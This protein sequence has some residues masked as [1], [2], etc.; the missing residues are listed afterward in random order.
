[1][2]KGIGTDDHH[3]PHEHPQASPPRLGLHQYHASSSQQ[4]LSPSSS[5]S[6]LVPT[7]S[8]YVATPAPSQQTA[9]N[10][11]VKVAG[12][13]LINLSV[14]IN[15]VLPSHT[16]GEQA[17]QSSYLW[18]SILSRFR[19]PFSGT[20][21]TLNP[22]MDAPHEP[23]PTQSPAP[24]CPDPRDAP[25][26]EIQQTPATQARDLQTSS[27]VYH[28]AQD[29]GPKPAED[30]GPDD[31]DIISLEDLDISGEHR[32]KLFPPKS[33]NLPKA[34]NVHETYLRN[35]YPSGHGYPCA[36]PWPMGPPIRIG[37]VGIH[38]SSGFAVLINL[39]DCQSTSLQNQLSSLPS[40]PDVWQNP[41]YLSEGESVVGGISDCET[42]HVPESSTI[43]EIRYR[44]Q[45]SEGAILAV[46]SPAELLSLKD[47]TPLRDWLCKHGM[48]LFQS[49]RPG[50]SDPL[51]VVTGTVMSSSWA[52]ATYAEPMDAP[53]NLLVLA[54]L[55]FHGPYS[56]SSYRWTRTG[57]AQARSRTSATLDSAGESARD[58]CLFLRGFL[59]TPSTQHITDRG[60]HGVR[61]GDGNTA[62]GSDLGTGGG[63]P[64][65]NSFESFVGGSLGSSSFSTGSHQ[66][67]ASD[68]AVLGTEPGCVSGRVV[69]DEVPSLTSTELYPSHI[70]NKRLLELTNANLAITHDDDWRSRLLSENECGFGNF[71][72][73]ADAIQAKEDV[74]KRLGGNIGMPND[75]TVWIG[76]GQADSA[77]GTLAKSN[78][79]ASPTPA[80]PSVPS[81]P[82]NSAAG[83]NSMDTQLRSAPSRA[84]RIGPIPSTATPATILDVFSPYEPIEYDSRVPAKAPETKDSPHSESSLKSPL[85]AYPLSA[86]FLIAMS[87]LEDINQLI[88]PHTDAIGIFRRV[89]PY[90]RDL[91][92]LVGFASTA[93]A[94]CGSGTILGNIVRASIDTR[95][96]HCNSVLSQ[97]LRQIRRLPYRS[98][99]RT[100]Y[101]YSVVHEWWTGNEPEEIRT[102]RL[103]ISEEAKAIGEWMRCLHSFWWASSQLLTTN[104]TFSM[105]N[106]HEF[107]KSGPI[108]MLR[109]IVIEEIMFLEPLQGERRSIPIRFVKSFEDVHM[110]IGMACRGTAASRFIEQRQYQLDESTTDATVSEENILQRIDECR[111]FEITITFSRLEVLADVCPRCET[112]QGDSIQRNGNGWVQCR[113]C[114]MKFNAHTSMPV[115]AKIEEIDQGEG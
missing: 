79:A 73:Q 4:R 81:D 77:P 20:S 37:D 15:A 28:K 95:M 108:S 76:S 91:T 111:V 68:E 47:H 72:D 103:S 36:N 99:P 49:L 112:S 48:D 71:V 74:P 13:D 75:Q 69:V 3:S 16:P 85:P 34:S 2:A 59:L 22:A 87:K 6:L 12:R 29:D 18:P 80:A 41:E 110:A 44:C 63:H 42:S 93:Y 98:F 33:M 54:H 35:I 86:Q 43:R 51:Y 102:I 40:P 83:P 27:R 21:V 78:N 70:I 32:T 92:V 61:N 104:S 31:F 62:S 45:K 53:Y 65:T 109:Q 107:L 96:T 26:P 114:G 1:M 9:L 89:E 52:T 39:Y 66:D 106:L 84:P 25:V 38:T 58:Q 60:R 64:T 94:A 56:Q 57:K 115:E 82:A 14:S 8:F 97:L 113:N 10:S 5:Q 30:I 24:I 46:T 7:P 101:G 17:L 19:S 90:L 11:T 23:Q 55:T 105:D 67:S 100:R 88:A 50:R